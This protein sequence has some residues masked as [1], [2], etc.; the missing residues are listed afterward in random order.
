MALKSK[1][2]LGQDEMPFEDYLMMEG[3]DI[4]EAKYCMSELVD[5]TLEQRISHLVLTLMQSPWIL[6][7][8]MTNLRLL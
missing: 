2:Q 5:M 6:W 1:L 7:M 3:E 4:I 8:L